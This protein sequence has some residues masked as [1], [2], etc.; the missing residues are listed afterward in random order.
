M[1]EPFNA[2]LPRVIKE[3]VLA[4]R[5]AWLI[6]GRIVVYHGRDR[7]AELW[8]TVDPTLQQQDVGFV[9]EDLVRL[10]ELLAEYRR[11]TGE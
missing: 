3:K 1:T 7:R 2:G 9:H 8:M 6:K 4:V 5:G 11:E 10:D